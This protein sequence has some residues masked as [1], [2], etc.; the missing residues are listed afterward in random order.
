MQ[1][2][3]EDAI[4]AGGAVALRPNDQ[5]DLITLAFERGL[6]VYCPIEPGRVK[7]D[8]VSDAVRDANARVVASLKRS[9]TV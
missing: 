7:F 9:H 6:T 2:H 4:I 1:K 3:I 5:Q 8:W